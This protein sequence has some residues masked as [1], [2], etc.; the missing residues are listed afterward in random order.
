MYKKL[1]YLYLGT[2]VI[3]Q[4][5]LRS[6]LL[7]IE[8]GVIDRN[9]VRSKVQFFFDGKQFWLNAIPIYYTGVLYLVTV[10]FVF[11]NFQS[12]KLN[13]HKTECFWRTRFLKWS[14]LFGQKL[15]RAG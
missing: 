13:N 15:D 2:T 7:F 12:I 10:K 3:D 1:I 11:I 6:N 8:N 5:C 9:R 4:K 14:V